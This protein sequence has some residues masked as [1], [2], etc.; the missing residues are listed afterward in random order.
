MKKKLFLFSFCI[1]FV[2]SFSCILAVTTSQ[3]DTSTQKPVYEVSVS[4]NVP[5]PMRDGVKLMANIF[6]PKTEG[7]FPVIIMR[8]PYG[9]GNLKNPNGRHFASKGY[10]YITQDCRGT[11]KSEGKW[12]PGI[13]ERNDGKDTHKWVLSQPWCNGSIGT[14][15]GSY[16]GYTQWI[17]APNAGDSLKAMF[18]VVPLFDWYTDCAY[19]GGASSYSKI[20]G[21]GTGMAKPPKGRPGIDWDKWDQEKRG[22][23]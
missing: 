10:V 3:I 9:K 20:M 8:T 2:M 16:V 7:T 11:G 23:L 17:V 15:G 12:Y 1:L 19:I 22:F 5:I 6:Q 4:E 13:N 18:T 21:W 14:T